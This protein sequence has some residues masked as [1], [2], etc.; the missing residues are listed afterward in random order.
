[1]ETGT[2]IIS[3]YAFYS[4]SALKYVTLGNSLISIGEKAFMG[5]N[6]SGS[7]ASDPHNLILPATLTTVKKEA[8]ANCVG[9]TTITGGAGINK[10]GKD[11]FTTTGW[12]TNQIGVIAINGIA[13][14]VRDPEPSNFD[15]DGDVT[16]ITVLN[17]VNKYSYTNT[18]GVL[19]YNVDGG[20]LTDM[21]INNTVTGISDSAFCASDKPETATLINATIEGTLNYGIGDSAF[22]NCVNLRDVYAQNLSNVCV[23]ADNAFTG[24]NGGLNI[25]R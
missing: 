19:Y 20:D 23:I 6:L 22:A 10:V 4:A 8:F 17:G 15:K 24:C 14:G 2:E 25:H 12:Y 11:A 9:V 3:D 21:V 5:S 16:R 1:M 7:V 18:Y 13:L